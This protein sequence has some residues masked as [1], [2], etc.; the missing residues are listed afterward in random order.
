V[1]R[2]ALAKRPQGMTIDAVSGKISWTPQA[3]QVGTQDVEV[4]VIDVQGAITTQSY[5][6]EVGTTAINQAPNITSTP[7]AFAALGQS[8]QYQIQ[9]TNPEGGALLYQLI[10][11][12][13]GMAIAP[14]TGLVTWN[15][16]VA[17]AHQVVVGAVDNGGLGIAQAFTLNAKANSLP[18]IRSTPGITATPGVVY[19]YDLQASDPDGGSL[20][21]TIDSTSQSLGIAIDSLGRLRWTPNS[22]QLGIYPVTL[23][24]TYEAGAKVTQQ[25]N[26]T[27]TADTEA[28]KVSLI[29]S[30]NIADIGDNLF[31]Q[32]RATDNVGIQNLQ[33]FIND[34]PVAIRQDYLSDCFFTMSSSYC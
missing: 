17:G 3:N 10:E 16:P 20:T 15:T 9:A 6:I 34:N 11:G 7:S 22:T 19:K 23:T 2:Y 33:L 30:T 27:V 26:L 5:K 25:L 18:V 12:P 29:G 28:P 32:A 4:Q 1:L 14:V 8:Y 21:Y 13:Q 31:F 24:I